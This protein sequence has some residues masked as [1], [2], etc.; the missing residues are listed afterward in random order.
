MSAS[1]VAALRTVLRDSG[2]V[3]LANKRLRRI[4]ETWG[5]WVVGEW[6]FLVLLSVTAYDRG[7][8]TAVAIVGAVRMIPGALAAPL[9]SLVADRMS[10]VRVL[11]AILLSW[12]VL[13][14]AVPAALI[15]DS[16][17]PLYIL[18]GAASVTSTLLRPAIN[19][20]VPQVIDRPE[21]LTAGNSTYSI[22]EALGSLVGPLVAGALVS[23]VGTNLRYLSVAVFFG[24]AAAI[25]S[26]IRTEFQPAERG[27]S[28]GWRR[29]L[30]PLAGFPA[31]VGPP[32]LRTLFVVMMAQTTTRGALN[33][34]VVAIAISLTGAGLSATGL[35]F[36]ALGAGGVIGGV[37]TLVGARWR[38]GPP[39]VLGMTMWGV[40]LIVIAVHPTAVVAWLAIA[41]IGLGNALAD[42]S[43]FTLMHRL[44]PDHLLG[45]AFG[46]LWGTASATQALGA[47]IAAPLITGLGLRTALL[48]VGI[49][50]TVIPL[51]SWF[52]VRQ[53]NA[54][55]FVDE[56]D[57]EALHRCELL[58]PLTRVALEQLSRGAIARTV[59]LGTVV[60]EQGETGETFFVVDSGQLDA[61]VDGATVR[62]LGPGDCFG[63][64]AALKHTPRTATVTAREPCRLLSLD[65]GDFVLAVTGVRPA[66]QAALSMAR[67]R[68][69]RHAIPSAAD[70][71]GGSRRS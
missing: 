57:V 17:L 55:L 9:L 10:R 33:V 58:A 16:L 22:V 50:M 28:V 62:R 64:I 52:S 4:V 32:R 6:G 7:G 48:V 47:A 23:T 56:R 37:I 5:L 35:F 14:A 71:D 34:L 68:I 44:I 49:V 53:V 24:V 8:T 69:E 19:A 1:G 36:A 29:I 45:R 60:V 31:L 43:G 65:G 15:A 25:S 63:E 3:V 41:A 38:P 30:E 39:F 67:E 18:V 70:D 59:A 61:Q 46:A 51:L 54:D 26:T 40:P 42:V 13:V 2:R 11:V 12:A 66:E 27:D 21:E 20:L